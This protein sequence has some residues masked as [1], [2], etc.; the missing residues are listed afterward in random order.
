M[1]R[2]VRKNTFFVCAAI[3]HNLE[4]ITEVIEAKESSEASEIF[5]NN[6]KIQP[7]SVLGPFLKKKVQQ[8][9]ESKEI[10]FDG[11]PKKANYEGWLVNVFP[12]KEPKDCGFL[13]FLK[14]IDSESKFEPKG[15]IILPI[16]NLRFI[17]DE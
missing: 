5:K 12:L 2:S 16:N 15:T 3:D 14:K 1:D 7:K 6:F 10:Q 17:S 9:I 13:V 8:T 4:L 11:L